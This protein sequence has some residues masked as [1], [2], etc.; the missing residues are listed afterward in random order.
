VVQRRLEVKVQPIEVQLTHQRDR[1]LHPE[2]PRGQV[3]A[4]RH[5]RAGLPSR[6]LRAARR[7]RDDPHAVLMGVADEQRIDLGWVQRRGHHRGED[8]PVE[9]LPVPRA[10]AEDLAARVQRGCDRLAQL[11]PAAR[12]RA[13]RGRSWSCRGYA[14]R[15]PGYP[16]HDVHGDQQQPQREDARAHRGPRAAPAPTFH[17]ISHRPR[18]RAASFVVRRSPAAAAAG[19]ARRRWRAGCW[20][21]LFG[22]PVSRRR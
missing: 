3:R 11:R 18:P 14:C 6:A 16:C 8:A 19:A 1:V 22:A 12:A 9:V 20:G 13:R 4:E 10:E 21:E 5:E 2:P 17:R 7:E 15:L